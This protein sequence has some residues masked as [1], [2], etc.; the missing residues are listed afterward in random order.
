MKEPG[1]A[2]FFF[3]RN[4]VCDNVVH[5]KRPI[6]TPGRANRPIGH[7]R[8]RLRAVG[9]ELARDTGDAV[10]QDNQ[11]GPVATK[12]GS[13]SQYRQRAVGVEL[14]RDTD[15]AV[16]Q[17]HHAGPVAIKVGSYEQW[18]LRNGATHEQWGIRN[19]VTHEQ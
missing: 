17:D 9:A 19:G 8:H 1:H 4:S 14:A 10:Q 13:Y 7:S 16:Q 18:G 12:V 5:K 3:V 6:Y 11:A 2:R 15:D